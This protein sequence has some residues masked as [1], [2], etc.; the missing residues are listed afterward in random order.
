MIPSTF[1]TVRDGDLL[2]RRSLSL[3]VSCLSILS[4]RFKF[5]PGYRMWVGCRASNTFSSIYDLLT[6]A[7]G[8]QVQSKR[9]D[10]M[11]FRKAL[12]EILKLNNTNISASN[13][14]IKKEDELILWPPI[15]FVENTRTS[16][17]EDRCWDGVTNSD[18][19]LLLHGLL[20]TV[21]DSAFWGCAV[22]HPSPHILPH[23][24]VYVVTF[25]TYMKCFRNHLGR[26]GARPWSCSY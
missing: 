21:R 19:A 9:I 16:L 2:N 15:V 18:M 8:S 25:T 23:P 1:L 6:H 17:G 11:G 12:T 26:F 22:F 14:S 7:Q 24:L 3:T 5:D 4:V 10:H 13:T 20:L